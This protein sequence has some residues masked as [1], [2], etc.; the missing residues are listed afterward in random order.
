MGPP[1][2]DPECAHVQDF[3]TAN[4]AY[5]GT[6]RRRPR[7][8][9]CL[10]KGCEQP[11]QPGH[12]QERYCSAAC[13]QA[14]RRWRSWRA[15]RRYRATEGGK[16]CRAGQS[17]RYRKRLGQREQAGDSTGSALSEGRCS[18]QSSGRATAV[19]GDSASPDGREGQ[20][21][22]HFYKK[23]SCDRPGCYTCFDPHSR[24]PLQR[25]CS[26]LCRRALQRVR[27]REARWR[28]GCFR[29]RIESRSG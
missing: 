20:R 12:P 27:E 15:R 9:R 8:R 17:R 5:G 6:G 24:S 22:A 11:F 19:T 3:A 14:A 18:C 1:Q 26:S 29:R 23:S 4:L 13:R 21:P 28:A 16:A 10:L 25:F 2:H 7:R